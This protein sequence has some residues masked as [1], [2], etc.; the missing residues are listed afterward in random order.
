[1]RALVVAPGSP[2]GLVMGEA[3][4]PTPAPNE[5]L[6]EVVSSSLNFGDVTTAPNGEPGSVPGWDAGGVVVKAAED[7]SG[8]AAGE[9]V[10]T[11]ALDGAWAGL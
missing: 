10:L 8:P 6:I 3:P 7:G 11:L 5:T 4:D 9:R 1:M 2:S